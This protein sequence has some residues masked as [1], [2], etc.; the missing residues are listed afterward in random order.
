MLGEELLYN[1]ELTT[2]TEGWQKDAKG[3]WYQNADGSFL[4]NQW[5]KIDGKWYHFGSNG[6][7]QT[8]WYKEGSTYYYLKSNGV[9]ASDEWVEND[10][11]YIDANGKWVEGKTKDNVTSG[12]WKKDSKGWWYQNADGSYPKNQWKKIGQKWYR[13]DAN[14]YIKTGWYKE[15]N[16]YYYLKSDGSMACDEWVSNGKYYIDANGHW[17]EDAVAEEN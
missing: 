14:G 2:Y 15:G 6:Y 7:M 16:V 9:L 5:K 17:V 13:F 11:Y 4:K 10:K 8:G 1:E 3:W 12:T